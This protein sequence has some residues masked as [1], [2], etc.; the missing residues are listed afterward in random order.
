MPPTLHCPQLVNLYDIRLLA[1][2]LKRMKAMTTRVLG[3]LELPLLRL[4][5]PP[6]QGVYRGAIGFLIFPLYH[7][8]FGPNSEH[9]VLWFFGGVLLALML[10]PALIR[11]LLPFSETAQ[12]CWAKQRRLGK[13]YDSHQWRKLF[14]I[15]LGLSGYTIILGNLMGLSGLLALLCLVIGGIGLLVWGNKGIKD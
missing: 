2:S 9:L 3:Y 12:E 14:W 6:L 8:L 1:V 15:G 10:V 13:R 4:E 11:R 7:R 5:K